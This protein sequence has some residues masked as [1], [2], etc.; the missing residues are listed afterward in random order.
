LIYSGGYATT[1][2]VKL[3][4][5]VT[6]LQLL[7]RRLYTGITRVTLFSAAN[8]PL[9][10]R[11]LFVQN[12]DQLNLNISSDKTAYSAKEKV[13]IQL[14]VKNRADSAVAGHFSI[15][16]IDEN[17][18]PADENAESTILTDLL[19]TSDLKGSIEQP[20]YYFTNVTGETLKNLDLVMLTH[21]Y[22]KFEW[23]Q[24]LA[25]KYQ[26]P[27]WRPE[28]SIQIN[29][30]AKNLLGKPL[31]K[32]TVSLISFEPKLLASTVTNDKGKFLF[33]NLVF[34]DT[35]KFILQSVNAKG[36][37][38]TRLTYDGEVSP[39]VPT[40]IPAFKNDRQPIP[41]PYLENNEK[42]HQQSDSL[43]LGK[44]RMLK[45]VK[46]KGI[47]K[48]D[49]YETQSFAGAGN[50][51]QVMHADE[52]A[53]IQGSLITSLNGRLRGV[54]FTVKGNKQV[55]ILQSGIGIAHANAMLVVVDGVEVPPESIGNFIPNEIETVEVL[56]YAN[57]AI[58]GMQGGNGVLIITTKKTRELDPK[59][60]ASVGIL[61]IT[62]QG[63]YKAR[64]FY[65]PKYEN[66]Q[67][68]NRPDLRSTIFWDPEVQTDKTGNASFNY[69]N[70]DGAGNYRLVVEGIDEK[71][72]IGRTVYNYKVE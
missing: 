60:I 21:G 51:D 44:A 1:V 70:A 27:A 43:G 36:S 15:A 63:Y 40:P 52:I 72:N 30:T 28:L 48:D 49:H 56:K 53:Q 32:G 8:D 69:Y 37:N 3:D 19:L 42:Q 12:Y 54:L 22:R 67:T 66:G 20:N 34:A 45:E 65:S 71:G 2:A 61:P 41:V 64:V 55:P 57:A 24:V 13:N 62:V 16:V 7:K 31:D 10:E 39:P 9:C 68:N 25:D 29:G 14:N 5:M 4:S 23:K 6:T 47:K 35:V 38:S 17:K 46:I 59:D 26:P 33:D 50:A 58:Y 11:L 18:T